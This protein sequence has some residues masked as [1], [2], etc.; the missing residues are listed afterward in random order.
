MI[1]YETY[2]KIRLSHRERGLTLAQIAR[3]LGLHPETVAKYLALGSYHRSAPAEA[4]KQT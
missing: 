3:E 4:Y 2:C 1:D